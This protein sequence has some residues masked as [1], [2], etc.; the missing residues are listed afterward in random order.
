MSLNEELDNQFVA[1]DREDA[2]VDALALSPTVNEDLGVDARVNRDNTHHQ[3]SDDNI[4]KDHHPK[5]DCHILIVEETQFEDIEKDT[6]ATLDDISTL[7]LLS[8]RP[9]QHGSV[10]NVPSAETS[11]SGLLFTRPFIPN[12]IDLSEGF[13]MMAASKPKTGQFN[14]PPSKKASENN[15]NL[16]L[17]TSNKLA[18]IVI[19]KPTTIPQSQIQRM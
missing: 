1:L 15:L 12:N 6:Q 10:L 4:P 16:G 18:T 7:F 14:R 13:R 11:T 8:D 9:V 2:G 3:I 17:S 19:P 5:P